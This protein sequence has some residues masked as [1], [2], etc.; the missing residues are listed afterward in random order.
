MG[1]CESSIDVLEE[2]AFRGKETRTVI[3]TYAKPI[4][5]QLADNTIYIKITDGKIE[6]MSDDLDDLEETKPNPKYAE[7]GRQ[8]AERGAK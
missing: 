1:S 8:L 3:K 2:H 5:N 6:K 4:T 7:S